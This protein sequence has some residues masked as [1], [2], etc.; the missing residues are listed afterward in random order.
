MK[1]IKTSVIVPVYNTEAYIE[2][3][4]ESIACRKN[5]Q[6]EIIVVDDGSTDN[7]LEVIKRLEEKYENVCVF[8][9]ENGGLSDARNFGI[10]QSHG[11]YLLL[12]FV[13]CLFTDTVFFAPSL[14][15][16]TAVSARRDPLRPHGHLGL[17][18]Q[19]L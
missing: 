14:Y 6:A 1:E 7:S 10:E 18:V 16:Q 8:T 3:C 9:K 11:E 12:P 19:L 13:I 2:E 15:I 17:H 4:I 5:E